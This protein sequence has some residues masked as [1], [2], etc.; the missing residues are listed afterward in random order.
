MGDGDGYSVT[1]KTRGG[2]RWGLKTQDLTLAPPPPTG[3]ISSAAR[4][5]GRTNQC[6]GRNAQPG[7][8]AAHHR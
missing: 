5:C 1:P 7:V 3:G 2:K 6:F 4:S 8:Q